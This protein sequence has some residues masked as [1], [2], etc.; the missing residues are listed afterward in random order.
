MD[1]VTV[2][3]LRCELA[4]GPRPGD[5]DMLSLATG[6]KMAT[7]GSADPWSVEH[8]LLAQDYLLGRLRY[9][10]ETSPARVKS[11]EAAMGYVLFVLR[12]SGAHTRQEVTCG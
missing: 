11:D 2:A 12:E 3:L 10:L 4:A 8:V 9:Y 7:N 1:E 5:V 6:L